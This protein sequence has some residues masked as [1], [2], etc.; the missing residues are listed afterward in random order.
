MFACFV[1]ALFGF[2]ER[3]FPAKSEKNWDIFLWMHLV[4]VRYFRLLHLVGGKTLY[5]VASSKNYRYDVNKTQN[6]I[7]K[8]PWF[9]TP[10]SHFS[11]NRHDTM[12]DIADQKL[13]TIKPFRIFGGIFS[14]HTLPGP[15]TKHNI[16]EIARKGNIWGPFYIPKGGGL[17]GNWTTTKI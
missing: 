16:K 6:S 14:A 5:I 11:R 2:C 8:I 13:A 4:Y 9:H 10:A 17:D 1:R 12:G 7:L 3:E 15:L